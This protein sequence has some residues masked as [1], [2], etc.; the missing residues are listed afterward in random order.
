VDLYGDKAKIMPVKVQCGPEFKRTV[1]RFRVEEKKITSDSIAGLVYWGQRMAVQETK[2]QLKDTVYAA[3]LPHTVE[4]GQWSEAKYLE[5]R[6]QGSAWKSIT[7]EKLEVT[8]EG[9]SGIVRMDQQKLKALSGMEHYYADILNSGGMKGRYRGRY[10]WDNML[11]EIIPLYIEQGKKT[12]DELVVKLS[13]NV[14][15]AEE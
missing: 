2:K 7:K 5:L 4:S 9:T 1:Q 11:R 8:P 14:F 13:G 12:R 10:Y 3:R 15:K 6:R